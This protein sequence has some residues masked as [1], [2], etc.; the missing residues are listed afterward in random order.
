M[1][2]II[3]KLDAPFT[4]KTSK[5]GVLINKVYSSISPK[6]FIKL[7]RNAENKVNPRTAKVNGITKAIQETLTNYPE[8]FWY[9]TKGILLSTQSLRLLERNRVEISLSNQEYEGVMDGG[10]NT[11]AIASFMLNS[12]LGI[13]VKN[14]KECKIIWEESY[15]DIV[16]KF[17]QHEEEYNFS[18]PIE[19]IYPNDDDGSVDQ[20]YDHIAEICSARNNNVQLTETA[21]GNKVGYYDYMKDLLDDEFSIIWKAGESGKIRSED[22]ISLATIPLMVLNDKNLLPKGI[23]KLNPISIYSQK[24]KCISFFNSIL[25]HTE[26]SDE[27]NGKHIL[28]DDS[29]KSA[30]DLVA[31]IMKFYDRLFVKFPRMYNN[32]SPGFARISS[33][34]QKEKAPLFKTRGNC[35]N[36]YPPAFIYPI[37]SGL[38]SLIVEEKGLLSWRIDPN[39]IIL[40]DL[41]L[42]IYIDQIKLVRYDAQKVGKSEVFYKQAK[43]I[44]GDYILKNV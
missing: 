29:V 21:K 1:K 18:I 17:S 5:E 11:F 23:K 12:L 30:L 9:K 3:L 16:E 4:Q 14:W 36:T 15:E 33:V 31:D 6:Q 32:I 38:T 41:D 26:I 35:P 37:V 34:T 42:D 20:F 2:N 22:V 25:D 43:S 39:K 40:E 19:I 28:L 27:V 24:S 10:H 44:F 7:M 8:L 13:K